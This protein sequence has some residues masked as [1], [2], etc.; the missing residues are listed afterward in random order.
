MQANTIE[1]IL[2]SKDVSRSHKLTTKEVIFKYSN[3][4]PLFLISVAIMLILAYLYLRYTVP[5]YNVSSSLLIKD[6]RSNRGGGGADDLE[7]IVFFK[8]SVNLDNEIEILKSLTLVNRVVHQLGL[9]Y[10]YYNEGNIRRSEIYKSSPIQLLPQK[11]VDSNV[12]YSITMKFK[13]ARSF[14]VKELGDA[15]Y[16]LGQ[17]IT[18]SWG[19]VAI[20]QK[21]GFTI[22]PAVDYI[23]TRDNPT[24]VALELISSLNIT[25][26]NNRATILQLNIELENI[27]KGVDILNKLVEE[28]DRTIVEDKNKILEKTLS[29]IEDRLNIVG[30]ELGAEEESIKNFRKN[31]RVIDLDRQSELYLGQYQDIN[32]QLSE[33]EIKLGVIKLIVDYLSDPSKKFELVPTN[34][35]IPDN[36]LVGLMNQYNAAQLKRQRDVQTLPPTSTIIA[37]DDATIE[38]LRVSLQENLRSIMA[39]NRMIRDNFAGKMNNFE[40][41]IGSIPE[42]SKE[43]LEK[44]RQ[45]EIKQNL[46]LFLY[47][48]REESEISRAATI[49]NSRIV[50]RAIGSTTPIKPKRPNIYRLAILIGLI[51]PILVIYILDLLNDKVTMKQDISK[52]TDTPIIGEVGHSDDKQVLVTTMGN[53]NIISEQFRVIRTNLPYLIGNVSRPIIMVTSSV[54]GEGKSFISANLAGVMALTGKKTVIL[55]FDLRKPKIASNLQVTRKTGITNFLIG[56]ASLEELPQPV[57]GVDNLYVISCGPIP[58]N[59]G[60]LLLE[61]RLDDLFAYL[62]KNFEYIII[63]TAPVGLVSDAMVLGRFAQCTLYVVRQRYTLKRQLQMIDEIHRNQKLPKMSLLVNDVRTGGT[64]GYYGYGGHGYG[65]GYGYGYGGYYDEK[66]KSR[67]LFARLL[68]KIGIKFKN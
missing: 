52:G 19:T 26:I 48:K 31:N 57:S 61:P 35:G 12:A 62:K 4:L 42:K 34:L 40:S 17:P 2:E 22:D 60:E 16:T 64:N 47:R 54:S 63:D 5:V 30:K 28:Y 7:S 56:Q 66:K 45:Q 15:T 38:A 1:D 32:N 20:V 41:Q 65:Y 9:E 10:R 18:F 68:A 49:S 58:P 36:T 43:L 21:P 8:Q 14:Q 13:D 25:P 44:S 51:L 6:D 37:D 67:S 27:H 46:Y 3:Y 55:E 50:D 53:R 33:Q 23:I 59:P 24:Q 39:S 11:I 29:F